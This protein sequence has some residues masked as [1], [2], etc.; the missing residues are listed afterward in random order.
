MLKIVQ[1]TEHFEIRRIFSRFECLYLFLKFL[2]VYLG[3]KRDTFKHEYISLEKRFRPYV[4]LS[5]FLLRSITSDC[6]S[7]FKLFQAL[8]HWRY[9]SLVL[10]L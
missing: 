6:F 10:N 8:S 3:L 7:F 9:G 1:I 5:K 4:S 2:H